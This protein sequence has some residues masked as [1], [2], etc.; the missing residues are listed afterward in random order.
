VAKF[1]QINVGKLPHQGVP[2]Q[3]FRQRMLGGSVVLLV[4]GVGAL[5]ASS[6]IGRFLYRNVSQLPGELSEKIYANYY[7]MEDYSDQ[8]FVWAMWPASVFI[9]IG[10]LT[11]VYFL[12]PVATRDVLYALRWPIGIGIVALLGVLVRARAYFVGRSLWLDEAFL[13]LNFR[14]R[15]LGELLGTPLDYGQSAPPGFLF[16]VFL[17]TSALGVS[18]LSLRLVPLLFGLALVTLSLPLAF[19]LFGS[20]LARLIF[21]GFLSFSPVLVYY[22]HEFKQYSLDAFVT[23]MV[24]WAWVHR[25]RSLRA[26][27]LGIVGFFAV[28]LSLTAVFSLT[29]LGLVMVGGRFIRNTDLRIA[30]RKICSDSPAY[31]LWLAGGLV[32]FWYLSNAGADRSNMGNWWGENGAFPPPGNFFD[33][34]T[35]TLSS[36]SQLVWLAAGH[37]GRAGP[38]MGD[39]VPLL[40]LVFLV[41][42]VFVW[43]QNAWKLIFPTV[44]VLVALGAAHVGLYP[45]SS[46]LNI[47]L[48]PIVILCLAALAEKS[49]ARR[50]KSGLFLLSVPAFMSL[51]PLAIGFYLLG[52]PFDNW[53]MKWL[54]R[55]VV[56]AASPGDILVGADEPLVSWYL[57]QE[58][59]AG[60]DVVP[61]NLLGQD[62]DLFSQSQ[63]WAISTHYGVEGVG[64][65]ISD[66][67]EFYCGYEVSGSFLALYVPREG[68][69]ES[70]FTCKPQVKKF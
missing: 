69:S 62:S 63:V 56:V 4:F 6:W 22:S 54:I 70:D 5:S 41:A 7:S 30:F 58:L 16:L 1:N 40:A 31:F 47:Y 29:A 15:S 27:V 12:L 49:E 34:V 13:A 25:E 20:N 66:T 10:L 50:R 43:R 45:F 42:L 26:W 57:S 8:F 2:G 68:S 36:L 60:P 55:E 61:L 59:P 46:R 32:H 21:V 38:G 48:V 14:D 37:P 18:D 52:R 51:V 9:G 65:L 17:A 11:L 39:G 24:L 28:I 3:V 33:S 19:R 35:W 44:L 64:D 23:V 67:H 53:D